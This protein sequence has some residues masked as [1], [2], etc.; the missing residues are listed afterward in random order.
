MH[1]AIRLVAIREFSILI[2]VR[3]ALGFN[4]GS[5]KG[6]R[7][8]A[9]DSLDSYCPGH[10]SRATIFSGQDRTTKVMPGPDGQMRLEMNKMT[11]PAFAE[12]LT[13]LVD[14]PVIDMTELK[15]N[16][17]IVLDLSMDTLMNV[18]RAA[19]MGIPALGARGE[20]SRPSD[21]SD[22]SGGSVFASV[23]QLGLKLESRR[24]PIDFIVVDQL[25]R[26]PTEN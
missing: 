11:M 20:P 8:S 18:A 14:R 10:N 3:G 13:R 9:G 21:A 26:M 7:S 15:G 1:K 24:A 2:L 12:M 5:L 19:G 4:G 6:P 22:P 17:Q 16:Y 25:E 23:Q